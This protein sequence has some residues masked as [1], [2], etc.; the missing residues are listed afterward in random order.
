MKKLMIK[1]LGMKGLN[2]YCEN[3]IRLYA[4]EYAA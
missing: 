1:M 2:E 4:A 3:F